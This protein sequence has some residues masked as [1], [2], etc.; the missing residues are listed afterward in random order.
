M[1]V[2]LMD[3]M[4]NQ[5]TNNIIFEDFLTKSGLKNYYTI[6]NVLFIFVAIY[7]IKTIFLFL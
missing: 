6:E 2:P 1:I 7:F 3:L 4:L 5:E